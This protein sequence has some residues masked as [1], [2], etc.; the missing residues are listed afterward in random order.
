M[1]FDD[2][3][4]I[5][6]N[7]S[8]KRLACCWRKFRFKRTSYKRR[9]DNRTLL[10]YKWV[11][12][13]NFLVWEVTRPK[14]TSWMLGR[15]I[16]FIRHDTTQNSHCARPNRPPIRL[17]TSN[18]QRCLLLLNERT[19]GVT[20]VALDIKG[21]STF[22]TIRKDRKYSSE[23]RPFGGIKTGEATIYSFQRV[24]LC[25]EATESFSWPRMPSP[26]WSSICFMLMWCPVCLNMQPLSR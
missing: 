25:L 18:D 10:R 15:C 26:R 5:F 12:R 19:R 11:S 6:T 16:Y 13:P 24:V 4:S 8:L 3:V 17:S 2:T 20:W 1:G 9:S 14:E 23:C 7:H 22:L 21:G